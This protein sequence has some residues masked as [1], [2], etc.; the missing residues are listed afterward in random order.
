MCFPAI[1][2]CEQRKQPI[3]NNVC[4]DVYVYMC[5]QV[6]VYV[7]VRMCLRLCVCAR[8]RTQGVA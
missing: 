6:C 4:Q 2:V 7:C 3:G 8:A 1:K 5:A